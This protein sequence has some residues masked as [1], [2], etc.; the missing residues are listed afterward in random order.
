MSNKRQVVAEFYK[1]EKG[2]IE[3]HSLSVIKKRVGHDGKSRWS[4]TGYDVDYSKSYGYIF[5][6]SGGGGGM[7]IETSG[8]Y[9]SSGNPAV[10]EMPVQYVD[11]KDEPPWEGSG[12]L[13]IRK[14]NR[15]RRLRKLPDLFKPRRGEDLLDWLEQN[16]IQGDSVWC[17][18]CDDHL[19]EESLCEHCWLC[20][21]TGMYSTPDERCGCGDR[22]QR[23]E[24]I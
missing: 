6:M 9:F 16:A 2:P 22:D 24:E 21:A 11:P 5:H 14:R 1:P 12:T 17:S 13:A 15:T 8:I 18:D 4:R 7:E 23:S 19:P 10:K 20:D 3:M